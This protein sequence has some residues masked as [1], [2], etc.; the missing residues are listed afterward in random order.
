MLYI[1]KIK[2]QSLVLNDRFSVKTGFSIPNEIKPFNNQ[3]INDEFNCVLWCSQ[4]E[5]CSCAAYKNSL[6]LLYSLLRQ[7]L[8]KNKIIDFS[9]NIYFKFDSFGNLSFF[10]YF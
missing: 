9:S 2:C 6:C 10:Y 4:I 8:N 1:F 3:I 5:Y 7:I